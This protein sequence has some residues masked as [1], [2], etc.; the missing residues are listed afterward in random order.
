MCAN[1]ALLVFSTVQKRPVNSKLG[2]M[3]SNPISATS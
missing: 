1:P 2:D 3:S